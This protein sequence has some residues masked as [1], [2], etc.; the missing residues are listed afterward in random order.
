MT[1]TAAESHRNTQKTRRR[2]KHKQSKKKG[3]K[4]AQNIS[5]KLDDKIDY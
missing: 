2:H 5:R 3:W 4:A 1:S